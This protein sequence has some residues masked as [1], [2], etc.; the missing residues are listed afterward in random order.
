MVDIFGFFEEMGECLIIHCFDFVVKLP[1][2]SLATRVQESLELTQ[3]E[4]YSGGGG[5]PRS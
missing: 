3:L 1:R 4:S 5:N 2:I